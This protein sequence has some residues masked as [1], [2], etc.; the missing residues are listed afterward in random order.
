MSARL[1]TPP[2]L[3]GWTIL[4]ASLPPSHIGHI[5]RKHRLSVHLYANDT[6]LYLAF[7][8]DDGEAALDQMMDCIEE[9]RRWMEANMLKLND[10]KTEFIV[11]GSNHTLSKIT[12]DVSTIRVRNAVVEATE[13]ARNIGAMMDKHLNMASSHWLHM[14]IRS[15]AAATF[16]LE[17]LAGSAGTLQR[18]QLRPLSR[19]LS[20]PNWTV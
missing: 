17:T 11:I 6:Q 2:R 4:L 5:A 18:M 16:T 14:S 1:W 10:A 13:S 19:H 8:P 7:K 12:D 15:P 3:I 20:S 9:I